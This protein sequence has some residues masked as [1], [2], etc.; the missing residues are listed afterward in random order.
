MKCEN[1]DI[2]KRSCRLSVEVYRY[3]REC[4]DFGF[5]DQIT[6]S[7]LSIASNI[8]E[9]IEKDSNRD[10]VRFLNIPEGSIAELITQIYIG[11]EIDYIKKD[12]GLNWKNELD[13][14]SKMIKS[15]KS[16]PIKNNLNGAKKV[17][18]TID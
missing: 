9:G 5:K 16:N 7:S 1:L 4:R 11:I 8:V 10:K 18:K 2:W 13:E 6:R 17:K 14:I 12:I 15:L 3:F